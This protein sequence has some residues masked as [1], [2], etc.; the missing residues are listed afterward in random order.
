MQAPDKIESIQSQ[1]S[2]PS[3][4]QFR[5]RKKTCVQA[6][7]LVTVCVDMHIAKNNFTVVNFP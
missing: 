6:V 1:I 4:N 5:E 2:H 7:E 3:S